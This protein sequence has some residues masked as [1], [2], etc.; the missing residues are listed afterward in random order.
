[1]LQVHALQLLVYPLLAASFSKGEA[2]ELL[3][4]DIIAAVINTLLGGDQL[5]W[6]DHHHLHRTSYHLPTITPSLPSLISS[7]HQV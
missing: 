7:L 5:P 2:K 6:Y 1:M 4:P 3:T